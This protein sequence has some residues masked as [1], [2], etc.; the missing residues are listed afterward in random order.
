MWPL[1]THKRPA[2]R[3]GKARKGR[4]K[5]GR[6]GNAA[7]RGYRRRHRRPALRRAIAV[8]GLA[9]TISAGLV[10]WIADHF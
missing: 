2:A 5:K 4:V 9:I 6:A 1:T 3:T 7:A 10:A 8:L